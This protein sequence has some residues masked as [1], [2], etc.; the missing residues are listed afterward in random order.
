MATEIKRAA[1]NR[2]KGKI[3]G[4]VVGLG[5]RDVTKEMIEQIVFDIKKEKDNKMHFIGCN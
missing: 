3:Q 4:F 2:L 1:Y 5:G